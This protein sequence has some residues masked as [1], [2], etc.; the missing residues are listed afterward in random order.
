MYCWIQFASILLR[1]S[2]SV[3]IGD[4]DC[5]F[6]FVIYVYDFGIRV[7]VVSRLG[8]FLTLQFSGSFQERC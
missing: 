3:F 7:M 4:F 6:L 8:V 5:N 1:L 2:A